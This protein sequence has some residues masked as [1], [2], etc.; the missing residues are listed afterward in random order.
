MY[1]DRAH[2][3]RRQLKT[4]GGVEKLPQSQVEKRDTTSPQNSKSLKKPDCYDTD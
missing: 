3:G 1:L 2:K 4:F